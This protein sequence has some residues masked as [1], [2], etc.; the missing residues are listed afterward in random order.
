MAQMM[1]LTPPNAGAIVGD[2]VD[3]PSARKAGTVQLST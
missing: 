3:Q 1:L 2:R